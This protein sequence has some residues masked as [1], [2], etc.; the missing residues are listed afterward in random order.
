MPAVQRPSLSLANLASCSKPGSSLDQ[1]HGRNAS[2]SPD[3]HQSSDKMYASK[4]AVFLNGK[5][6]LP[7]HHRRKAKIK[8][9][10]P[11]VLA[12]L[13][14]TKYSVGKNVKHLYDIAVL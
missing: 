2:A 7:P 11:A 8:K 6:P 12:N 5:A 4:S 1:G 3:V 14:L 10:K 9:R 13:A